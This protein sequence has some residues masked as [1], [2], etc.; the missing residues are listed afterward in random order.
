MKKQNRT[1]TW[2]FDESLTLKIEVLK[3]ATLWSSIVEALKESQDIL[4]LT[5]T[6]LVVNKTSLVDDTEFYDLVNLVFQ[7]IDSKYKELIFKI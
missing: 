4:D 6:S 2:K 1:K 5:E 7:T 3:E